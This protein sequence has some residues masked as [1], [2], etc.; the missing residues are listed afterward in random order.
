MK[1]AL[2][3]LDKIGD[4]VCT[5]PVDQLPALRR[6]QIWWVIAM[7]LGFIPANSN[8]GRRFL[9]LNKQNSFES[10][11]TLV[12][13]FKREGIEMVV[14]FQGPWW[15]SAA[16]Y[17]AGVK[18]RV[19]VRSQWHSF[20]FLNRS[21]RQRRSLAEK[22][23]A[24]YNRELME[25]ALLSSTGDTREI[26]KKD[27]RAKTASVTPV[28]SL[29][30]PESEDFWNRM[31]LRDGSYVVVHPGM[32]G[33]A[34]NWPQK[35]Y[36]TLIREIASEHQVVITGTPA[37]EAWLSDIRRELMGESRVRW[38]VG[39]AS[40]PELLRILEG[41]RVVIAPSTGVAHLAASLGKPVVSVFSAV[42]VQSATRWA[43]RGANVRILSAP[44]ESAE[45]MAKIR[46]EDVLSQ[47]RTWL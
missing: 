8:P 5:L 38:L 39:E 21:L 45:A 25:F 28:L 9:Q 22:H 14:S 37:D 11:R 12:R 27:P 46:V 41:A 40:A 20:L 47:A 10:F 24:D 7:G 17:V 42:R 18:L 3:R 2:V 15:V 44:D 13:F 33:S 16:A 43:P 34:K 35:Y 4:L 6:A 1:I 32:A 36:A 23:E 19:G 26:W 31:G 30:A 29:R